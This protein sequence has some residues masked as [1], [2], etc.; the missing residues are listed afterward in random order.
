MKCDAF[1]VVE[2]NI[3][4]M[5]PSLVLTNEACDIADMLR[6]ASQKI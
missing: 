4:T 2:G 5:C 1:K 6:N 3:I